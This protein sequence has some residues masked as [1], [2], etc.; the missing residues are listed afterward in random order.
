MKRK[1]IHIAG[2]LHTMALMLIASGCAGDRE[3]GD[4]KDLEEGIPTEVSFSISSRFNGIDTRAD[5]TAADPENDNEMINDWFMV[6]ADR[7][8]VVRKVITRSEA[9]IKTEGNPVEEETFRF[10]LPSGTYSVYAF[11]NISK[12]E[13]KSATKGATDDGLSFTE[14]I[15][16]TQADIDG[17]TWTTELNNWDIESKPIPMSGFLKDIQVKTTIEETFSIEVVRMV[18]KVQLLFS[19]PT[20]TDITVKGISLDPVTSS[21]VS[22]FPRN[23][24]G[25]SYTHL[26]ESPYTALS[27]ATY[28]VLSVDYTTPVEVAAGTTQESPVK[29]SVYIKESLSTKE[30]DGAFTVGLTVSHADGIQEHQQYNIT[31]DIR[32][33]IN[34]NDWIVIPVT[35]SQYDVSVEALFYPPIGGYPAVLS[36]VAPDGSQVFTFGTEGEFAIV[37][38][39]IDK[40][41]GTHLAPTGYSIELGTITDESGIFAKTPTVTTTSASLPEE[42]TGTLSTAKG[43]ATV[44]VKVKIGTQAY[45]R[46][47]YIIRS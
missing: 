42:I 1:N 16:I 19:N 4:K 46:T 10:I 14:G 8:N 5:G 41:S 35:L 7:N 13:L 15:G 3:P 27:G 39:V 33:Y 34:R 6:F 45:I 11:A 25:I 20:A 30:N 26:G 31:K 9:G 36:T 12:E 2:I 32:G 18:A 22:L 21:G 40:L 38:H 24:S 17:K 28:G 37:P 47:I 43:K 29:K 44:E 23:S